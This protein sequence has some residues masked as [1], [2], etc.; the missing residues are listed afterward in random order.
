MLLRPSKLI[1]YAFL[2]NIIK[3]LT[4][5]FRKWFGNKMCSKLQK[6]FQIPLKYFIVLKISVLTLAPLLKLEFLLV[7][8]WQFSILACS[9]FMPSK[10]RIKDIILNS[11]ILLHITWNQPGKFGLANLLP[12]EFSNNKI[13]KTH[14]LLSNTIL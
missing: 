5:G 12:S 7:F 10:E 11:D 13:T 3:V 1:V 9:S 8:L 14:K 2:L 6:E 4:I